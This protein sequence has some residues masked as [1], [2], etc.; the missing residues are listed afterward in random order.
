MHLAIT[1]GEKMDGN[2]RVSYMLLGYSPI[3][4]CNENRNPV[5]HILFVLK[6]TISVL[7]NSLMSDEKMVVR[8]NE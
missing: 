6:R 2:Q 3:R 4:K 8:T 1:H 7:R 5:V